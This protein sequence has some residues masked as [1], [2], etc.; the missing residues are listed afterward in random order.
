MDLFICARMRFYTMSIMT[1]IIFLSSPLL[2]E[3]RSESF[4]IQA[5]DTYIKVLAPEQYTPGITVILSNKTLARLL[6]KVVT[7]SGKV[8]QFV[9]IDS[10]ESVS[11]KIDAISKES[12]FFV[13]L[14]PAF[15]EVELKFGKKT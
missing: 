4:W 14:V 11:V 7:A 3:E 10:E 5:H 2:S 13:P 15:Q 12:V 9:T 6:G 8:L 1:F